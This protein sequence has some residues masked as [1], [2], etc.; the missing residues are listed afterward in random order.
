MN[1]FTLLSSPIQRL[2]NQMFQ[3]YVGV[4][5]NIEN[6]ATGTNDATLNTT[7]GIV[8]FTDTLPPQTIT[9]FILHNSFITPSTILNVGFKYTPSAAAPVLTYYDTLNTGVVRFLMYNL[10][11]VEG[12]YPSIISFQIIG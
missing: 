9:T 2:F 4:A 12:I 10:S 3:W 5:L 1:I 7:T 8:T 11:S 6:T